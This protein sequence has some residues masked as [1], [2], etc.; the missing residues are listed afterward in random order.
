MPSFDTEDWDSW[1]RVTIQGVLFDETVVDIDGD[2]GNDFDVKKAPGADGA[3]SIDK[4]YSPCQPKLTW[5]LWTD[6]HRAAYRKLLA[7]VQPKPGK[8]APPIITVVHPQMTLHKKEKFK[9]AKLHFLKKVGPQMQQAQFDL[10]EYF[11]TPKAIAKPSTTSDTGSLRDKN[12]N[13]T[14]TELRETNKPSKS[15]RP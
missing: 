6:E 8:Q 13:P 11:P 10:I 7:L 15:P 9:I 2:L 1:D 14:L 3:P 12:G 5:T 4:G